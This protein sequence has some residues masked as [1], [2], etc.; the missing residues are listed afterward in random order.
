MA[1][2][3]NI[4]TGKGKNF[5]RT[6]SVPLPNKKRVRS[7]VKRNPVGNINTKITIRN[8]RTKRTITTTKGWGQYY[9]RKNWRKR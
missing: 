5:T 9:G 7:W 4:Q 2:I 1:Y 3:I 6:R 8:T